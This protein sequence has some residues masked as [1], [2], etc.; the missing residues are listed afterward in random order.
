MFTT[1]LSTA[2]EGNQRHKENC[3]GY[4]VRPWITSHKELGIIHKGED[5]NKGESDQQLY[6][7]YQKDLIE[8]E[9]IHFQ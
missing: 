7:E 8:T 2:A 6:C 9:N 3:I 1:E 4:I 5:G